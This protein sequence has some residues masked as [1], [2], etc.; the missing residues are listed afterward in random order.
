MLS[1]NS[2]NDALHALR[3]GRSPLEVATHLMPNNPSALYE[4]A[5]RLRK[6]QPIGELEALEAILKAVLLKTFDKAEVSGAEAREIASLQQEIGFLMKYKSYAVKA[7]T[8]LGYSIFLQRPGQG[9][10][11]QQ[12]LTKKVEIF[13]VLSVSERSLIFICDFQTWENRF[14]PEAFQGWLNGEPNSLYD[15]LCTVPVPGDVVIIDQL[16]VVHSVIGCVIDEFAND[17]TDLV[18][19]LFDQNRGESVPQFFNRQ[20][21]EAEIREISPPTQHSALSFTSEGIQRKPIQPI[22]VP[23]GRKTQVGK[24]GFIASAFMFEPD[25]SSGLM[26]TGDYAVTLHVRAGTANIAIGHRSEFRN[27]LPTPL[28]ASAGDVLLLPKQMCYEVS[29]HGPGETEIVEHK[30]PWEFA[31]Q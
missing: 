24:V 4:L 7:S 13:R 5:E 26:E 28:A 17:S 3:G 22:V 18:D 19:R 20:Y 15:S 10:S 8:P 2:L 1:G 27:A 12:H 14:E 30:L 29:C 25:Q 16:R 9:F 31:F 11:F 6:D 23:G 21:S